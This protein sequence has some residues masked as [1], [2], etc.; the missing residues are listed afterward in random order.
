MSTSHH[1]GSAT[2]ARSVSQVPSASHHSPRT[3]T[4][5]IH[6]VIANCGLNGVLRLGSGGCSAVAA[7][8]A[9]IRVVD[10][11]PAMSPPGDGARAADS[12]GIPDDRL[13]LTVLL[14]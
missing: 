1:H 5:L 13:P 4:S 7:K 6:Q 12:L 14:S 9:M 3:G 8:R 11:A 10:R 2:G